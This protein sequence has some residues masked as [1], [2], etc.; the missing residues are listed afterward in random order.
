M[1]FELRGIRIGLVVGAVFLLASPIPIGAQADSEE[2]PQLSWTLGPGTAPLGDDLAEIDLD[3]NTVYLDAEDSRRLME[4]THNPISGMEVGTIAA[5][6]DEEGWFVIFEFDESGY[7]DDSEREDLDAD[8]LLASIR[9]GTEVANAERAERGWSTMSIIGWHEQPHYDARTNNL[10]W[11]I[12]GE[13]DE[14]QNINRI[15]KLLGRRGVMTATL[16]AAPEELD[17]A[18]AKVDALLAGYRYRPGSTYAEYVPGTDKLATYGLAA[19]VVGGGAAALAQSGLLA[20]LWKP[21]AVFFVALG[22]GI[23]RFFFSGRS[24]EHD[25]EQPIG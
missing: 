21:I 16:V 14:G 20:K 22:A 9:E 23:K 5:A 19:L 18:M 1:R 3:E 6:S 25:P 10:S 8:A 15:V 17:S 7:V 11:A 2:P 13:T 12:I 24:A 4:L